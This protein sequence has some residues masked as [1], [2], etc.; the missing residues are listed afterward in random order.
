MHNNPSFLFGG[1]KGTPAPVWFFYDIDFASQTPGVLPTGNWTDSQGVTHFFEIAGTGAGST[2]LE[3]IAN[4]GL[5]VSEPIADASTSLW[6]NVPD[7]LTSLGLSYVSI[8]VFQYAMFSTW[9]SNGVMTN[10]TDYTAGTS[11][12]QGA[13]T[14]KPSFSTTGVEFLHRFRGN[15]SSMDLE[16]TAYYSFIPDRVSLPS[17]WTGSSFVQLL[18][19]ARG[20]GGW[21]GWGFDIA[22]VSELDPAAYS[23]AGSSGWRT[24]AIGSGTTQPPTATPAMRLLVSKP[25][26]SPTF[27]PICRRIRLGF[28]SPITP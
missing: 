16:S 28:S 7:V 22:H 4:S 3:I 19:I 25:T 6:F 17:T 2:V 27:T 23:V 10:V 8:P 24:A 12:L 11:I 1:G 18:Q 15:G 5:R 13:N 21:G 14:F 9:G 26:A 20:S